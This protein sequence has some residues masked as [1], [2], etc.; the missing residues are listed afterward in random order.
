MGKN[1]THMAAATPTAL[2][3]VPPAAGF[4]FQPASSSSVPSAS[5]LGVENSNYLQNIAY[6]EFDLPGSMS[7]SSVL[8]PDEKCK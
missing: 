2:W 7:F 8:E 5:N 1:T 4:G 6:S 3:P